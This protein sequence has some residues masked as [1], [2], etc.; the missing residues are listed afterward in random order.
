MQKNIGFIGTGLMG[1]PMSK[2]LVDAGYA[3]TVW[4]RTLEKCDEAVAHGASLANSI[5]QLVADNDLILT[6]ITNTDAVEAVVFS[7]AFLSQGNQNKTLVDFSSI[8]P[9]KTR[10]FAQKLHEHTTMNWIDCPVSG[11]V[12][13]AE[14][15]S[16]VMMERSS[17]TFDPCWQT[18]R[19]ASPT[20]GQSAAAKPPKCAIK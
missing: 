4:N 20:W 12:A 18:C 15:G 6:C 9:A 17:T 2:R 8:D 3:V 11:G 1:T 5:E 10:E 16:L 13:G 19:N 14:S 7:D